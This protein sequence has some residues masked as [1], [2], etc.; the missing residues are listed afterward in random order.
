MAMST[1][2]LG[3]DGIE[4]SMRGLCVV[5]VEVLQQQLPPDQRGEALALDQLAQDLKSRIVK[6]HL[7]NDNNIYII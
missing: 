4:E 3:E 6:Q 1:K 2:Y 5:D 7:N